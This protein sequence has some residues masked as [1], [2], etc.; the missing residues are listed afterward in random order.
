MIETDL[1]DF[2]THI[3][4][5][6]FVA[7]S[8]GN[9]VVDPVAVFIHRDQA[10]F[11]EWAGLEK[12]VGIWEMV[13]GKICLWFW[14]SVLFPI[15]GWVDEDVREPDVS[16]PNSWYSTWTDPECRRPILVPSLH[17]E[18]NTAYIGSW[19]TASRMYL[20]LLSPSSN[21]KFSSNFTLTMSLLATGVKLQNGKTAEKLASKG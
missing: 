20:Q 18:S 15:L 16:K 21:L 2:V 17:E 3:E 9:E 14:F 19:F 6:F 12:V 5:L 8:D 10:L 13:F 11:I 4:C 7:Q 1:V